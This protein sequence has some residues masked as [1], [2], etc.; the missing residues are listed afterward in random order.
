[1][2]NL[3]PTYL[4][5]TEGGEE[6]SKEIKDKK[7]LME[8]LVVFNLWESLKRILPEQSRRGKKLPDSPRQFCVIKARQ[9]A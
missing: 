1:M 3:Y 7:L 4:A 2:H 9:H 5:L 6:E 8:I